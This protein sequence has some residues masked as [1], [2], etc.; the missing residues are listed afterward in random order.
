MAY[1]TESWV[2]QP[3]EQP[4]QGREWMP[5]LGRATWRE[6]D[7]RCPL[8]ES[9]VRRDRPTPTDLTALSQLPLEER[10]QH[11]WALGSDMVEGEAAAATDETTVRR[12]AEAYATMYAWRPETRHTARCR[13]RHSCGGSATVPGRPRRSHHCLRL[14]NRRHRRLHPL[15]LLR[16][17][18]QR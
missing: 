1:L 2:P 9:W 12:A 8:R 15:A 11:L 16:S 18:R 3:D 10:L 4:W 13:G 14:P 7:G 6:R 5:E 17:L